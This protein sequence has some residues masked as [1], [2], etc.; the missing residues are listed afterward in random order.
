MMNPD[1][2]RDAEMLKEIEEK[3]LFNQKLNYNN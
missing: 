3:N 2:K 1:K